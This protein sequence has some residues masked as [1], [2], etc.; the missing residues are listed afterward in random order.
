MELTFSEALEEIQRLDY[1]IRT[2][3]SIT[4]DEL[5]AGVQLSRIVK[6]LA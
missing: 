4:I 1:Y 3:N 6:E 5:R 2:G